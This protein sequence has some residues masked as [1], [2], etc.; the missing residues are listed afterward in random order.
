MTAAKKA[1]KKAPHRAPYRAPASDEDE[2]VIDQP[3]GKVQVR[4]PAA[5]KAPAAKKPAPRRAR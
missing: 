4:G 5:K 2:P 3:K 1:A